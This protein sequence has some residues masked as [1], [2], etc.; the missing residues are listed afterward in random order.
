[1]SKKK[2]CLVTNW[3]PTKD[4][5]YQGLFFRE[6]AIALADYYNFV[7]LHYHYEYT[8][9]RCRETSELV[10]DKREYN[11]TEYTAKISGSSIK[12]KIYNCKLIN[13]SYENI[14][15]NKVCEQLD[16]EHIDMFYSICGQNDGIEV[17]KY[18]NYFKKPYIVSE[19]GP[20]P[21]IGTLINNET[22]VAIE[23]ADLF[24]AISNDKIRQ[25]LMQNVKLPKIWYVGNMVDESKF[26]YKPSNNEIKTFITV[27]ANV[28]YKNY[29]LLID[30]FNR[31][32]EITDIPFK[33]I[34][35]GYQAN[36]GYS[37]DSKQLEEA[38]YNSQFAQNI[39]MI[40][41]VPHDEMVDV[42]ARADAFVMTSIQEGQP[43]SALEAGCCGLPIFSTRCGGVEDYVDDNIGRIVGLLDSDKLAQYLKDYLEGNITFNPERIR[44]AVVSKFGKEQFVR[45][46]V[47]GFESIL[48]VRLKQ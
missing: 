2:I 44:D 18:A 28:F 12:K 35:L 33:V 36:K 15:F 19:H 32:E 3:Y 46:M 9:N 20:F 48:Q 39:E 1:M 13:I 42:F 41:N 37:Q 40:P 11:I 17:A 47:D 25:I 34:I 27:G 16:S 29:G 6:Q 4:N 30:T 8:W 31:L 14:L 43:V 10:L 23:N 5:P 22:K 45:N 24:L 26:V 38:L 7:V 21:W